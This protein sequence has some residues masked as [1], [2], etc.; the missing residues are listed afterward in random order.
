MKNNPFQVRLD[1]Y[2]AQFFSAT[3]VFSHAF[4]VFLKIEQS[5]LYLRDKY[6]YVPTKLSW[7]IVGLMLMANASKDGR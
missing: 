5:R 4:S 6:I 3:G 7:R 2:G 1:V